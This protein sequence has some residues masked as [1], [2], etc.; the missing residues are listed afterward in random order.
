[1][2]LHMELLTNQPR[3]FNV[4]EDFFYRF[5]QRVPM[6]PGPNTLNIS[7]QTLIFSLAFHSCSAPEQ[8]MSLHMELLANQPGSFH[9]LADLLY[10]SIFLGPSL[11]FQKSHFPS[12][13]TR[14]AIIFWSLHRCFTSII[15]VHYLLYIEN[16]KF[17]FTFPAQFLL[18]IEFGIANLFVN[19]LIVIFKTI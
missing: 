12:H 11:L 2:L 19:I 1:M 14:L 7:F 9:V 17:A 3:S 15:I 10:T 4:L 13:H 16:P 5:Y 18:Y 8:D 6:V